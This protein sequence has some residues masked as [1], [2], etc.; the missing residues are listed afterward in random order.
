VLGGCEIQR[1]PG[2]RAMIWITGFS[3]TISIT[4]FVSRSNTLIV[5]RTRHAGKISDSYEAL[6]QK[7]RFNTVPNHKSGKSHSE[8]D[9]NWPAEGGIACRPTDTRKNTMPCCEGRRYTLGFRGRYAKENILAHKLW[10]ELTVRIGTA[11]TPLLE[12]EDQGAFTN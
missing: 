2:S 3:I 10:L 9:R 5:A 8:A 6:R 1:L 4:I 12:H 11:A 7:E